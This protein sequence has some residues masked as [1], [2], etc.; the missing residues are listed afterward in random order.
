MQYSLDEQRRRGGPP[1]LRL[2]TDGV[3]GEMLLYQRSRVV[4]L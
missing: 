2:F 1:V 4:L 3:Q